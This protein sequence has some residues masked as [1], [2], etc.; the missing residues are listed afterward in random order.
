M[1]LQISDLIKSIPS[2]N[3]LCFT[4]EKNSYLLRDSTLDLKTQQFFLSKDNPTPYYIV[5]FDFNV[6]ITDTA[7]KRYRLRVALQVNN[8][9][10]QYVISEPVWNYSSNVISTIVHILNGN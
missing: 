7:I 6:A 2:A 5:G 8:Q 4:V 3:T 1:T 10:E 9:I